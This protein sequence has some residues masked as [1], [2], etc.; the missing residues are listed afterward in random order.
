MTYRQATASKWYCQHC[1]APLAV[2]AH[3][4]R[5]MHRMATSLGYTARPIPPTEEK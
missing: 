5:E 3:R 1:G 2:R 4:I